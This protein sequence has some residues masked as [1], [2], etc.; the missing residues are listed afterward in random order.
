M[1]GRAIWH[2]LCQCI[3]DLISKFSKIS[4]VIYPQNYPNQIC[5]YW[6]IT[7]NNK[8]FVLKLI[9]FNSGQ[10]EN[11]TVNGAMSVNRMI[12]LMN[13]LPVIWQWLFSCFYFPGVFLQLVKSSLKNRK[14][15]VAVSGQ[16]LSW[17]NNLQ[18]YNLGPLLFSW[19]IS[20]FR[21]ITLI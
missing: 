17:A 1:F 18:E 5:D 3:F 7:P 10:L 19:Y 13:D 9:S 14:Q 6:L 20:R 4:R 12:T 8:H 11:N 2:K 21:P 16:A 15:R